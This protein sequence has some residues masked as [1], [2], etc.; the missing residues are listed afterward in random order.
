MRL[1]IGVGHVA[2]RGF[3]AFSLQVVYASRWVKQPL[4]LGEQGP[5]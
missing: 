5:E 3:G 2:E 4:H 1:A